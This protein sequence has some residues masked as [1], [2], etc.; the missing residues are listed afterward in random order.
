MIP[1]PLSL[2]QGMAASDQVSLLH[3]SNQLAQ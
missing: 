2:N 3:A 1:A